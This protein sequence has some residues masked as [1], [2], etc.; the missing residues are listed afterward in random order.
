MS[1]NNLVFYRNGERVELSNVEPNET[2]LDYLRLKEKKTGTKEGCNEGDCGACTIALGRMQNGVLKYEPVNACIQLLGQ[3]DGC[4]IV[5]VDDLAVNG[6]LHPV[7]EAMVEAHGSQCGFCTPGF[8]MSLFALYHSNISADREAINEYIAGNLCRCTGYRPIAKAAQKALNKKPKDFL[9]SRLKE[10]EKQLSKLQADADLMLGDEDSFFAAPCSVRSLAKL[11]AKHPDATILA[12][13]TDVGLWITK[14]L[15]TL[16]KIIYI[17]RVKG[18]DSVKVSSKKID[19]GASATYAKA[20]DALANLHPDMHEVLSRLGSRHVRASGTI[21][22]NIANGSPIGDMPPM[23]IAL[24]AKLELMREGKKREIAL[25]DFFI[26]YGKQD[27]KPSEFVSKVSIPTLQKNEQF[28]AW[29]ISKRFDQDI[30]ALLFAAKFK[31]K[32]RVIESARIACGGMAGTPKRATHMEAALMGVNLDMLD[33]VENSFSVF[34]K[35]FVP[36]SDM[37]ASADYRMQTVKNLLLKAL[38]EMSMDSTDSTRV[39]GAKKSPK[40][41]A[42]E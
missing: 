42:A 30:S 37:R 19:I 12:G 1:R 25:E 8:V 4:D 20:Y 10:T 38:H 23:L 11:V 5:S 27:L 28:K 36:M 15:K 7:Q 31:L 40:M 39:I 17:G 14:Q 9:V 18:L 34:E 35:D 33:D 24:D 3:V 13:A 29:K 6:K 21:G 41:E 16:P 26:E 2:L 22:G 32:G